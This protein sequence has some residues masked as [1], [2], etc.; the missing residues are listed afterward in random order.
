MFQY[1]VRRILISM[2]VLL[3]VTIICFLIINLAPG[4]P[5]DMMMDPN[6][7]RKFRRQPEKSWD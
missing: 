4:D 2:P 7:P 5:V 1:I 6:T 3:G